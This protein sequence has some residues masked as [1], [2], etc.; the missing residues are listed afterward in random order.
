MSEWENLWNPLEIK[1][2]V[3]VVGEKLCTVGLPET[4]FFF[5]GLSND[6]LVI[7]VDSG[8]GEQRK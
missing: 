8:Q 2:K 6:V 1:K 7:P 4:H 5:L 3:G